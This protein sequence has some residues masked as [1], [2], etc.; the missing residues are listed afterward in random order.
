M[1]LLKAIDVSNWSG[2]IEALLEEEKPQHVV[3]RLSTENSIFKGIA[4]KQITQSLK[5]GATVS[6]YVWAYFHLDPVE[7]MQKALEVAQDFPLQ[8]VWIDC[9]DIV[10]S[11]KLDDWLSKA[12]YTIETGKQKC[13]IYTNRRW[14][15]SAGN[16]QGFSR[17]PLWDVEWDNVANRDDFTPYGGW[18]R[19][20]G[21]QYQGGQVDL[22]VF[23]DSIITVPLTD[24]KVLLEQTMLEL[25]QMRLDHALW[26][27]TFEARLDKMVKNL[28]KKSL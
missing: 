22:S 3:V 19:R 6:G 12:V 23:D 5:F 13:G 21:K 26:C 18:N 7:E 15:V 4:L 9:E 24:Y 25:N 27:A 16:S 8:C 14:W 10:D 11:T 2:D 20:V 1:P 17:L 28:S